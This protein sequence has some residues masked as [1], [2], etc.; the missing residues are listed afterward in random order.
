MV[1]RIS[2]HDGPEMHVL[3]ICKGR[4]RY[5]FLWRDGDRQRL[6]Q[7][8]GRFASNPELSFTWHDAAMLCKKVRE[9]DG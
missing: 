6:F 1:N 3:A 9:S 8:Q 7:S 2:Q 4:E 5:V